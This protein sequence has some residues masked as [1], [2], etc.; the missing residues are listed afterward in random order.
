MMRS[1]MI[2]IFHQILLG[3]KNRKCDCPSMQ[4]V[5]GRGEVYTGFWWGDRSERD[6]LDD[7]SA[8]GITYSPYGVESFMCS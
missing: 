2:C 8:D 5:W 4:C 1:L 6:Q 3:C 7:I